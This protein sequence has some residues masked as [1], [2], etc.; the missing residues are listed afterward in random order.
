M[1]KI[2]LPWR[3]PLR[4]DLIGCVQ[5]FFLDFYNTEPI[6][7][8]FIEKHL[9]REAYKPYDD[10]EDYDELTEYLLFGKMIPSVGEQWFWC[11]VE[12]VDLIFVAE[13]PLVEGGVYT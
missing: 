10:G 8:R 7:F 3:Q 12:G 13:E 9:L 4:Q 11:V 1:T 2:K 5:E 6:S